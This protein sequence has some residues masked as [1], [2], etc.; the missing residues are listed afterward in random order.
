MADPLFIHLHIPPAEPTKVT[1]SFL[2]SNTTACCPPFTTLLSSLDPQH[3]L[4]GIFSL[5]NNHNLRHPLFL[6]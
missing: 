5:I 3:A 4:P 2:N 1:K 6:K